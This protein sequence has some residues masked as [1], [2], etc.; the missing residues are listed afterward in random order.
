[1]LDHRPQHAE[2]SR[3]ALG[4]DLGDDRRDAVD[5]RGERAMLGADDAGGDG[6]R[7]VHA[8]ASRFDCR[9]AG[10][11]QTPRYSCTTRGSARNA[12]ASPDQ[13]TCPCSMTKRRSARSSS[14]PRFLSMTI[15]DSPSALSSECAGQPCRHAAPSSGRASHCASSCVLRCVHHAQRHSGWPRPAPPQRTPHFFRLFLTPLPGT[16]PQGGAWLSLNECVLEYRRG[17]CRGS[18][19]YCWAGKRSS[20]MPEWIRGAFFSIDPDPTHSPKEQ[21]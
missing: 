14:G 12:A 16:P 13:T 5:D 3:H 9:R 15:S 10:G 7:V 1:M 19:L 18:G 4:A 20:G 21:S 2:V 17:R 6:F 11:R 8:I